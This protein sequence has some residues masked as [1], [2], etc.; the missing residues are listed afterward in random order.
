MAAGAQAQAKMQP[1]DQLRFARGGRAAIDKHVLH[2]YLHPI[3]DANHLH[4]Q[5]QAG[6]EGPQRAG[7]HQVGFEFVANLLCSRSARGQAE[8]RIARQHGNQRRGS[9]AETRNRLLC[10]RWAEMRRNSGPGGEGGNGQA[11]ES[12]FCWRVN[13]ADFGQQ[14]I[15]ALIDR[16]DAIIRVKVG[17]QRR[18][19]ARH[20]VCGHVYL[21]PQ[22]LLELQRRNDLPGVC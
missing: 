1:V 16:L 4:S 9:V 21:A 19:A 3:A 22:G 7:H 2:P 13:G 10:N 17:A 11:G 6:G 8:D 12:V 15:A 14:A 5:P 18:Q 20:T